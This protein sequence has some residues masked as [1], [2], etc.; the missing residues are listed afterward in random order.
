MS[1]DI[2]ELTAEYSSDDPLK[3]GKLASDINFRRLEVL[4]LG[5]ILAEL[6]KLNSAGPRPAPGVPAQPKAARS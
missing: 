2:L 3:W 4:L 1:R 6:R 5:E